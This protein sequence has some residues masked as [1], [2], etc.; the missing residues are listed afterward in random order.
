MREQGVVLLAVFTDIGENKRLKES[1]FY[2]ENH[3]LICEIK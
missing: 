2:D 1:C 3:N